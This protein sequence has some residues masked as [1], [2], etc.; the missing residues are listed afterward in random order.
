[1]RPLASAGMGQT[2]A[3]VGPL[4]SFNTSRGG[5]PHCHIGPWGGGLGE[6]HGNKSQIEGTLYRGWQPS[7][8]AFQW[9]VCMQSNG[10]T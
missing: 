2:E 6:S 3:R 4:G 8:G 7:N 5:T 1:M 10:V 9:V